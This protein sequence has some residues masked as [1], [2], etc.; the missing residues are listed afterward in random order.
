MGNAMNRRRFM[1]VTGAASVAGIALGLGGQGRINATP[2]VPG[3]RGPN[4]E[5]PTPD[6]M[7][8]MHEKGV[9]TFN[10]NVGKDPNFWGVPLQPR[11]ETGWS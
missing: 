10:E 2:G 3:L 9:K 4:Q 1:R 11:I 8:A 6:E 5:G 7:D